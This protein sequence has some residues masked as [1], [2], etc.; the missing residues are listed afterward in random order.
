MSPDFFAVCTDL[1]SVWMG[2]SQVENNSL[3]QVTSRSGTLNFQC[4]EHVEGTSTVLT[5]FVLPDNGSLFAPSSG[6]D[7]DTY[8]ADISGNQASLTI[9]NSLEPFRGLL[10]CLSTSGLV[11]NVRVVA[12]KSLLLP[13]HLH[14]YCMSQTR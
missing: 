11:V 10:K 3:V 8:R 6:K 12:G 14:Y 9:Q 4:I 13:W 7:G 2:G 1:L 5:W